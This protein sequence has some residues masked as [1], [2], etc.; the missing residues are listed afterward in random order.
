VRLRKQT[1]N[2][3]LWLSPGAKVGDKIG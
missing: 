1:A 2:S 3:K